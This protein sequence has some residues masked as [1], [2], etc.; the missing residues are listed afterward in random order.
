[1]INAEALNCPEASSKTKTLVLLSLKDDSDV[2]VVALGLE[3]E[4]DEN[5]IINNII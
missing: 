4:N 3:A 1:M 5:Q 2:N